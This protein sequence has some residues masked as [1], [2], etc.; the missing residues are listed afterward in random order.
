MKTH[1]SLITVMRW[2]NKDGSFLYDIPEMERLIE[3]HFEDWARRQRAPMV[4][5]PSIPRIW[6]WKTPCAY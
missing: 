2:K 3:I 6:R 1:G 4:V 5:Q